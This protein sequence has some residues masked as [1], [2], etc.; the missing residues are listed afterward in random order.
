MGYLRLY[1]SISQNDI[2]WPV[3]ISFSHSSL[4]YT[5][6]AITSILSNNYWGLYT[7]PL[8][9]SLW[10]SC[11]CNNKYKGLTLLSPHAFKIYHGK[12]DLNKSSKTD[13]NPMHDSKRATGHDATS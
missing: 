9:Q 1:F 12:I 5:K 10:G 7:D 4:I 6:T 2:I 13:D 3:V 11:D 8:F